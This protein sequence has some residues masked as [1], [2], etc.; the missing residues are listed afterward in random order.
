M[1]S[2]NQFQPEPYIPL[3]TD[4]PDQFQLKLTEIAGN[5]KL[6]LNFG[7]L[8][9]KTDKPTF[10]TFKIMDTYQSCTSCPMRAVIN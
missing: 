6:R 2:F 5:L 1:A 10:K 3:K 8:L 4:K 9:A 7:L